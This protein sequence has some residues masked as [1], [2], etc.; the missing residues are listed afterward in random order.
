MNWRTEEYFMNKLPFWLIPLFV[1]LSCEKKKPEEDKFARYSPYWVNILQAIG[2]CSVDKEFKKGE[3]YVFNSG[4]YRS[5]YFI[6]RGCSFDPWI[7]RIQP[8]PDGTFILNMKSPPCNDSGWKEILNSN[9]PG[10]AVEL[11][12]QNG[13]IGGGD[14]RSSISLDTNSSPNSDYKISFQ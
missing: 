13:C 7:L 1:V 11:K 3:E 8:P 10:Q 14:F 2:H 5:S 9:V 12:G 4:K 6:F